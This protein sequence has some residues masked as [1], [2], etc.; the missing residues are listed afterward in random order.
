LCFH[1]KG[2]QPS[3][4]AVSAPAGKTDPRARRPVC[5][6]FSAKRHLVAR[7]SASFSASSPIPFAF[8]HEG[9]AH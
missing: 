1:A 8:A 2:T 3:S 9:V 6:L 5:F 7:S 4:A